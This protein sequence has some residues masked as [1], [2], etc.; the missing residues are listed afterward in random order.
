MNG[1]QGR[2]VWRSSLATSHTTASGM[3][4]R[5]RECRARGE[6]RGN[7]VGERHDGGERGLGDLYKSIVMDACLT[8]VIQEWSPQAVLQHGS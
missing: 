4:Q 1:G 2:K 3:L 5:V 7:C 6:Q 8:Q